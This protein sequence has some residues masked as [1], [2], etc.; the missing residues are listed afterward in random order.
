MNLPTIV[1][2]S[3]PV[4]SDATFIRR[5]ASPIP[6]IPDT[7]FD[8]YIKGPGNF[9][10]L[11]TTDYADPRH[12]SQ[13]LKAIS[14]QNEFEFIDLIKPNGSQEKIITLLDHD[15][16]AGNFFVTAPYKHYQRYYYVA[17]LRLSH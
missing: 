9:M 6:L 16:M 1:R 5:L 12:Q 4:V 8:I 13:E 14:G 2:E 17:N 7:T 10:A 15:D 11:V 3:F